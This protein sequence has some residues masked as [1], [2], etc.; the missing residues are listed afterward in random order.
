MSHRR[1]CRPPPWADVFTSDRSQLEERKAYWTKWLWAMLSAEVI[2]WALGVRLPPQAARREAN[3]QKNCLVTAVRRSL[4]RQSSGFRGPA[5]ISA[6]RSFS[7]Q[8]SIWQRKFLFLGP[9]F[10][11]ISKRARKT[12]GA[13]ITLQELRWNPRNLKHRRCWRAV[14]QGPS[15]TAHARQREILQ[16]SAAPGLSRHHW[17]TD[18]DLFDPTLRPEAWT[19]DKPLLEVY[20]WMKKHAL[21]FG[22]FQAYGPP[23]ARDAR[24]FLEERWHWSYY[25]MAQALSE[26]IAAHE[27][28]FEAGLFDRWDRN[29][30]Y[31]SY[32]RRHWRDYLYG[33]NPPVWQ[34]PR[35]ATV[36]YQPHE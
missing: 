3:R 12:C 32:P 19:R 17:G 22:F 9:S 24:G 8:A 7:R 31:Y 36:S 23:K 11:R 1:C 29:D 4:W 18:F 16:F 6:R 33:I 5:T 14:E 21:A 26:F 20:D 25:P 13:L 10:D 35:R 2:D 27:E 28:A 34:L 15:L 30:A